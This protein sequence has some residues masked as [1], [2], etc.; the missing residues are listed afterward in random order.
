MKVLVFIV[1]I[2]I[3]LVVFYLFLK[4]AFEVRL[5][6][7]KDMSDDKAKIKPLLPE[8]EEQEEAIGEES[9]VEE[10]P[11][12]QKKP[13]DADCCQPS[14]QKEKCCEEKEQTQQE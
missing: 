8:G 3:A 2:S 9:P 14:A 5:D 13:E 4:K 11:Q 7:T 10:E 1:V 12:E 6:K